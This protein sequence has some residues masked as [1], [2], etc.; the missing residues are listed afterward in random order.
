MNSNAFIIGIAGWWPAVLYWLRLVAGQVAGHCM[1]SQ[2]QAGWCGTVVSRQWAGWP[3]AGMAGLV[4]V[5]GWLAGWAGWLA[6]GCI[7]PQAGWL[8]ASVS[9]F[10]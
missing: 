7:A 3:P 2:L 5:G 10:H 8:A 9:H 4:A 1:A 6:T